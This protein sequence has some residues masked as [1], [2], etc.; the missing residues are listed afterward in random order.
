[1]N[2]FYLK[3][4]PYT[5]ESIMQYNGQDISEDSKLYPFKNERLQIWL[6]RLFPILQEECN[7][8]EFDVTFQGTALDFE[9]LRESIELFQSKGLKINTAYIPSKESED[10]LHELI[11]LFEEMQ[12]GPFDD[13][14]DEQIKENFE[15][16]L[17][18]EFEVSVIA[19]MSSGKSTLINSILGQ[20][21]MPAKNEACTATIAQVKDIDGKIGFSAVC[22][23][24][25][26]NQIIVE[27]DVK[28]EQMKLFNE[29]PNISYIDIE[30]DIPFI[31]SQKINLVLVDT[32][33]PNNSRNE[34]HRDQ[35]Y[36]IIK[37][38]S[39]PVVLY[40]LNATALA[41]DDDNTLLSSVAEAM[42]VGGK[43]SKDRFIFAV[44]KID[45]FDTERADSIEDA[46]QNIR[47]YLAKY[48]IHNP[49][50]YPTSAE[51][52]KVIRMYMNSKPLT[53]K[54]EK[55]LEEY[56][57]FNDVQQMHLVQYTPLSESTK[58]K[59]LQR[60]QEAKS[61]N[62]PY[63]EALVH[64]GIPA[65][66]MA[67]NEYLDKYAVTAK[68]K[69]A[70]DTFRKKVEEKRMLDQLMQNIENNKEEKERI[71]RQLHRVEQ[72]LEEGK[73]T[74][75][76]KNKIENLSFDQEA[77]EKV[78]RIKSKI[79]TLLQGYTGNKMTR[80]EM[81]QHITKFIRRVQNL[82]S[83]VLTELEKMVNEGIK[84]DAEKLVIEYSSYIQ[85]LMQ[86]NAVSLEKFETA[87]ETFILGEIPDASSLIDKH[88]RSEREK[89]GEKWVENTNKKWYKP[90]TWLDDKGYYKDIYENREY[91]DASKVFDELIKPIR[92]DFYENVQRARQHIIEESQRLKNFFVTELDKLD[93]VIKQK[94]Q[95]LKDLTG[96]N[97]K[98]EERIEQDRQKM[99]WLYNFLAKLDR[100]L[101]V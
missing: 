6:D 78:K 12:E 77:E 63:E 93:E 88:K 91:V 37:N 59:L 22:R 15:K 30:G 46:L 76:F 9:D 80:L 47:S 40:V 66:E 34:E 95:E 13:L 39:K 10:K 18:S 96:D 98:L 14:K 21:L 70:V 53:R 28:Y 4:N 62:D 1:M 58:N 5:V 20:E 45:E 33:G 92:G 65:I 43:Q 44:N 52:A 49:N 48:G 68:I 71:N 2:A 51:M 11:A 69:N 19:T 99:E 38:S 3:Y 67:I 64:S 101:E 42:K 23:D 27:Q 94:V 85:S 36:R 57:L 97:R 74:S 87:S 7:T 89:V 25:D 16:A 26:K 90:W 73:A 17:S 72:Q 31:H 79:D 82:Q 56:D 8:D 81:E 29:D 54:Q 84:R 75:K 24:R 50:I 55:T 35:T 86:E 100:I 83:D 41:T 61:N 32:P 60:V